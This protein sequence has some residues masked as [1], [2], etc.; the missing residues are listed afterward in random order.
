MDRYK[1]DIEVSYGSGWYDGDEYHDLR[2]QK[3]ENGDWVRYSDVKKELDRLKDK[4][5]RMQKRIDQHE[6][7]A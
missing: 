1:I 7:R 4:T 2:T 6:G 3:D 5:R